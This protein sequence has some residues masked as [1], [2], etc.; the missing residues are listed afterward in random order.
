MSQRQL[1]AM[2]VLMLHHQTFGG[3]LPRLEIR[4]ELLAEAIEIA[5]LPAPPRPW[6][7]R[8]WAWLVARY[9]LDGWEDE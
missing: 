2:A 6:Y 3:G 1:R 9:N 7:R 5:A 4:P 8:A